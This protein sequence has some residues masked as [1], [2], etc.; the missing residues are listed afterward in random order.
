MRG[1]MAMFR[2]DDVS[3]TIDTIESKGIVDRLHVSWFDGKYDIGSDKVL[4]YMKRVDEPNPAMGW[5]ACRPELRTLPTSSPTWNRHWRPR[6][7]K[8]AIAGRT[9]PAF[10]C[11]VKQLQ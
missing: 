5:R 7:H 1:M 11:L 9:C 2:E 6:R 3:A 10:C 4:P 8:R